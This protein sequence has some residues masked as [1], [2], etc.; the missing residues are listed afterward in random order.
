M[1]CRPAGDWGRQRGRTGPDP[2]RHLP[3]AP[4]AAAYHSRF[5]VGGARFHDACYEGPLDTVTYGCW[6]KAT[7]DRVGPFDEELV[8]NQ[9][10]EHNLRITRSGGTVWQSLRIQSW[11]RPAPR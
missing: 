8:R 4:V 10:D 5:A 2:G 11:Y 9:D 6:P 1:R 7:F 3:P